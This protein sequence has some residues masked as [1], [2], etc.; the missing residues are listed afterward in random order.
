MMGEKADMLLS[1][2][3]RARRSRTAIGAM[4][5][6]AEIDDP[7]DD[8]DW[9]FRA[10]GVKQDRLRSSWFGRSNSFEAYVRVG[11]NI[12]RVSHRPG[13]RRRRPDES[14]KIVVD[15]NDRV[16]F[17]N[18]QPLDCG[19][20]KA[21]HPVG[22]KLLPPA[23][24]HLDRDAAKRETND[25][26]ACERHR[27]REQARTVTPFRRAA[28]VGSGMIV[29][30]PIAV[31]WWLQIA[32]S[33]ATRRE[34]FHFKVSSRN[35]TGSATAPMSPPSAIDAVTRTGS[36]TIRPWISNAAMPV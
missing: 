17:A 32:A 22:L 25:D 11:K 15:R 29:A 35:P 31:K 28:I 5:L 19:V 18:Q 13:C 6:A 3:L 4:R 27:D 9:Y 12:V 24:A 34:I 8:F 36:Q 2:S 10:V 16:A 33:T 7:L 30:A 1:A 21:A 20:G 23:I 14:R 26:K